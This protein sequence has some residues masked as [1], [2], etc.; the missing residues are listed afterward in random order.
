VEGSFF[1][2]DFRRVYLDDVG[3]I[4]Y[5]NDVEQRYSGDYMKH[6]NVEAIQTATDYNRIAVDYANSSSSLVLPNLLAKLHADV[7][8]INAVVQEE[9]LYQ[10]PEEFEEAMGRLGA[11]TKTLRAGFGVRLD[12]GGERIYFVDEEGVQVHGMTAL[13]V[14]ADLMLSRHGK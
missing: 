14:M 13:A 1:R 7:V 10:T 12:T 6:L 11:I 9:S 3:R 2:E 5:A 4:N 8:A